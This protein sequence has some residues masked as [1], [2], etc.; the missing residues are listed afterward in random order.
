M[1]EEQKVL[2]K[3]G[4]IS[5]MKNL[6]IKQLSILLLST[7]LY[8][9]PHCFIDVHPTINKNSITLKWVFDEMSSQML[10]MDFDANHDTKI[11]KKESQTI[12]KEAFIHLKEYKYYTYFLNKKNKMPTPDATNFSASIQDFRLAYTFTL[13]L[14]AKTTSIEFYDEDMYSAFV[15][16]NEF[17]KLQDTNKK[18]K[19]KEMD[20]DYFFGYALELSTSKK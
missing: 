16:E 18:L 15:I 14:D 5:S 7:F 11:S 3:K 2:S 20:N 17:I 8:A 13:S 1:I 19:L 12:Y 9:H 6:F 10:I 4:S